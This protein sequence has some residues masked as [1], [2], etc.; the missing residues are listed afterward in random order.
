MPRMMTDDSMETS[1]IGG[2]TQAFQ[3]SGTRVS[4]LSSTEY[5]LV[6]I[7]VDHTGSTSLFA[8]DLRKTLISA[9]E[10]CKKSQ[11]SNNLLVRALIFSSSLRGG[12]EELHGFKPLSEINTADYRKFTPNGMTPLNDAVFSSVAAE[13]AYAKQLIDQDFMVNGIF[14]VITDGA[15]NA[16]S[17]TPAMIKAEMA[18][19]SKSEEIE[20]IIGILVG[21]NAN[22]CRGLLEKFANEVGMQYLDAGD[23]TPGKLAK[24][25]AFVSQSVSSQSQSLGT[26]G[27]SQ[28]IAATI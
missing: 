7:A 16:S 9:V 11:R 17:S 25:A 4:H 26:G 21:I 1:K 23:A 18:R 8:D 20:S 28:Q 14:I 15:E 5:T 12:I 24:L 27:P 22:D 3:F 19:A 10:S 13:C 6:T 2:G